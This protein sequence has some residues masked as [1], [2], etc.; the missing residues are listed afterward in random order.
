MEHIHKGSFTIIN[1]GNCTW[2][3]DRRAVRLELI[4]EVRESS[5]SLGG[6]A[7]RTVLLCKMLFFVFNF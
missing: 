1:V 2:S 3:S 7:I 5:L 6:V 4:P